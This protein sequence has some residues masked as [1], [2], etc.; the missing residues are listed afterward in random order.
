M[1]RPAISAYNIP[2]YDM[3]ALAMRMLTKMLMNNDEK[4]VEKVIEIQAAPIV[5]DS[6][7]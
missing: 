6:T 7:N 4:G 2:D 1:M 3:G 5:R